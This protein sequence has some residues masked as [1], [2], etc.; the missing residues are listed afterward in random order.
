MK[1]TPS[2][3]ETIEL[4]LLSHELRDRDFYNEMLDHFIVTLE[5]KL[6]QG[7]EFDYAFPELTHEFANI[8]TKSTWIAP[9]RYGLKGL[10]SKFIHTGLI[11]FKRTI[12]DLIR[13]NISFYSIILW[14][15]V[16]GLSTFLKFESKSNQGFVLL[17]SI[18]FGT[19]FLTCLAILWKNLPAIKSYIK[20]WNRGLPLTL[21]SKKFKQLSRYNGLYPYFHNLFF[22]TSTLN[23]QI[24]IF[25]IEGI[26][27]E[28]F[29]TVW[30]SFMLLYVLALFSKVLN[31]FMPNESHPVANRNH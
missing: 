3:I 9:T 24:F 14:L 8:A 29:L 11:N 28:L 20:E 23:L 19:L 21:E 4:Y 12:F 15:V 18:T 27:K 6:D 1:L 13:N 5:N 25:E 26:Y 10:E 7:E 31:T 22:L 30:L 17:G 16:V 2:Q